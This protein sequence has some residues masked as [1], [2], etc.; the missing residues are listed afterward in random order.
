MSDHL[1]GLPDS[2]DQWRT[3]SGEPREAEKGD[4]D[5]TDQETTCPSCGVPFVEHLGLVGACRE[6]MDLIG[7]VLRLKKKIRKLEA[8]EQRRT[9]K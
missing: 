4:E 9:K 8:K 7:E 1:R 3:H 2:Y 6:R 5:M